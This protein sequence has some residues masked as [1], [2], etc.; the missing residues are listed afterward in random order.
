MAGKAKAGPGAVLGV[1]ISHYRI[2]EN[3]GGGGMGV[4][5]KAENVRLRRARIGPG[6]VGC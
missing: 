1:T 2:F 5:H 6:H 4:V 3:L